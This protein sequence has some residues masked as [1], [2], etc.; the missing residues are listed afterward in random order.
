VNCKIRAHTF[1]H[2]SEGWSKY[3]LQSHPICIP[4]R[5]RIAY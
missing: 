5:S 4:H 2:T 3:R 1:I